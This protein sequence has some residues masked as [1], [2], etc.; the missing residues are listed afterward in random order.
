MSKRYNILWIDDQFDEMSGFFDDADVEGFDLKPF[1]SSRDGMEFLRANLHE[2]DAVILDAK[3]FKNDTNEVATE[4]GLTASLKKIA[5]LSGENKGRAIPHVVFTGQPDLESDEAFADR[6]DGIAIFSKNQS[7]E[8]LFAKLR[9]LIGDAPDA[10][11]RNR[12]RGTYEACAKGGINPE[13]W[14][15]LAPV[16]GSAFG[17]QPLT[18]EPYNDIRKALEWVF[19]YLHRH[20]VIHE[21]L[22]EK[23]GK[24]NLQGSS[25]FLAGNQARFNSTGD[26]VSARYAILPKLLADSLKL[27]IAVI[28]PGSHTETAE[29]SEPDRPSL[30]AVENHVSDNHLLEVVALIAADFVQWAVSYVAAN[31]DA[32]KNRAIWNEPGDASPLSEGSAFECEVVSVTQ[33]QFFA[34][35]DNA[36]S[37]GGENVRI[38][39]NMP[40]ASGLQKGRRV[41]VTAYKADPRTDHWVARTA[42]ILS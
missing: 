18:T 38:P 35:P 6:M 3:V 20:C 40:G 26:F 19:R 10:S 12:F 34:K 31:P 1:K 37:T 36:A 5:E 28:Q 16:L 30:A 42:E 11:V 41:R 32:D 24:V 29:D 17:G 23:D 39:M 4:K 22:V 8:S 15:L 2:V 25:H 13:C 33:R 9:E 7:N 21:R 27:T 14:K